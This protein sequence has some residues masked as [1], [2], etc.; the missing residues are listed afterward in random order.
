MEYREPEEFT[1][2]VAAEEFHMRMLV[3]AATESVP[4]TSPPPGVL[5]LMV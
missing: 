3:D 4:Y 1:V 5:V 2:V